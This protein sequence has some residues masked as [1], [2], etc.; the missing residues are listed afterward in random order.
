MTASRTLGAAAIPRRL[1]I[2]R[3][4]HRSLYRY[5][6]ERLIDVANVEVILDRRQDPPPGGW[7]PGTTE[8]PERERR[9]PPG[10]VERGR[11]WSLGYRLADGAGSD[12]GPSLEIDPASDDPGLRGSDTNT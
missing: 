6:S 2:V 9:Q 10:R 3:Q 12:A 4:D 1:I 11:W 5:L 7:A 8:G